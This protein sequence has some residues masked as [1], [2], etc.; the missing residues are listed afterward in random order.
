ME[1]D[2]IRNIARLMLRQYGELAVRLMET[3]AR[4][5]ARHGEK[6]RATFWHSVGE[7]VNRLAL[8]AEAAQIRREALRKTTPAP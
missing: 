1:E 4:N 6:D 5:C 7:E 8:S 3:R 2:E